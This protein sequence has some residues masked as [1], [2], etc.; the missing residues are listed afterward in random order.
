M[1][2]K[3]I[4]N[5]AHLRSETCIQAIR[6]IYCIAFKEGAEWSDKTKEDFIPQGMMPI[7]IKRDEDGKVAEELRRYLCDLPVNKCCIIKD[8]AEQSL[9]ALNHEQ[10]MLNGYEILN[11]RRTISM[12]LIVDCVI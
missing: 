2:Q 5:Q 3:Q 8:E 6:E 9:H 10:N 4:D 7:I 11:D 12:I 1:R